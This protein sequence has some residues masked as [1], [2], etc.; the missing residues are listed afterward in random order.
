M[1]KRGIRKIR[2]NNQTN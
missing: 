1:N 2:T